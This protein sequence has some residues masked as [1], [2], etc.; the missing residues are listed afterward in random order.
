VLG[1][2]PA[3]GH[4]G[5]LFEEPVVGRRQALDESAASR[6]VASC[7]PP[8][9]GSLATGHARRHAGLALRERWW[10]RDATPPTG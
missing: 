1:A 2:R 8:G 9:G 4:R 5:L 6:S 10:H 3:L 7:L